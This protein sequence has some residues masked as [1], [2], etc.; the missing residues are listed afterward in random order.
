MGGWAD[1]GRCLCGRARGDLGLGQGQRLGGRRPIQRALCRPCL[2]QMQPWLRILLLAAVATIAAIVVPLLRKVRRRM[3]ALPLQPP[4]PGEPPP[5]AC[6]NASQCHAEEFDREFARRC[7]GRG[8]AA[9][10]RR[11]Y[12]GA[13]LRGVLHVGTGNDAW[14]DIVNEQ[15]RTLSE[16][17]VLAVTERLDVSVVADPT[18]FEAHAGVLAAVL[19]RAQRGLRYEVHR[20]NVTAPPWEEH[21]IRTVVCAPCGVPRSPFLGAQALVLDSH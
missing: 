1:M 9:L 12:R 7:D 16:C 14:R 8:F 2:R 10:V 11:G 19:S 3:R 13:R 20:S 17:G 21:A 18:A 4:A 6:Q 5:R 15:L